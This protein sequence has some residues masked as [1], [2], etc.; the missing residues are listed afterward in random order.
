MKKVFGLMV[1]ALA[2]GFGSLA[3]SAPQAE[4]ATWSLQSSGELTHWRTG[5]GGSW[6]D[7]H[8]FQRGCRAD[9]PDCAHNWVP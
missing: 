8:V 5:D 9:Q 7:T 6:F 2:M 4:A 1:L 3:A